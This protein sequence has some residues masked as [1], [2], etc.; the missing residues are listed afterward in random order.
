MIRAIIFQKKKDVLFTEDNI[1]DE[2][3]R[4]AVVNSEGRKM[5]EFLKKNPI[6]ESKK[7]E[8][9]SIGNPHGATIKKIDEILNKVSGYENSKITALCELMLALETGNEKSLITFLKKKDKVVKI[10][11]KY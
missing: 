4:R 11:T 9:Q 2:I 3:M 6:T 1:K 7:T 5:A 8:K 10:K